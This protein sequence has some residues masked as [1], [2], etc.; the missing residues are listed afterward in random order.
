MTGPSV[1][2]RVITLL[3][4]FSAEHRALT[5]SQLSRRANLPLTTTHRL[6]GELAALG[7]LERDEH[8]R[9]RIGVRLWEIASL[10]P[11]A[12]GLREAAMPFLEDLFDAT[13]ENVQLAVL[14]GIEVLYVERMSA[15]NAIPV[16][17]RVGG[18]LPVHATAVGQVLLANSPVE[19]Q[20]QVLT[21]PLTRL[22][23]KTITSP[24]ELRVLLA[25]V[26]RTGIAV[27]DGHVDTQSLSVAA[28]IYGPD[29][30][31]VAGLSIVVPAVGQGQLF[32]PAVRSAARGISRALG[33][34]RAIIRPS[35]A[36][37]GSAP[38]ATR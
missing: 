12:G 19:L 26:R 37:L 31:V 25:E 10:A 14:D 32:A 20:E 36:V 27:A 6:V 3:S 15:R 5:L 38:A 29:D 17:S 4:A 13:R 18:R 30:T 2:S 9:Y 23:D 34:P 1:T 28:P 16:I 21:G 24:R 11:R 7:A 8:G 33:A 22:T 35:A